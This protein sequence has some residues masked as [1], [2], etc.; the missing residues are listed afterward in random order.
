APPARTYSSPRTHRRRRLHRLLGRIDSMTVAAPVAPFLEVLRRSQLVDT[1]RLDAYLDQVREQTALPAD[2]KALATLLVK[3][4]ILTKLQAQQ[5][6]RGKHK[7]FI[8]NRKDKLL[9]LLG[10]GGMG[11]VFLCEHMLLK[12]VVAVKMLSVS[13]SSQ[14]ATAKERF[15]RE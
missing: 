2:P 3:D 15:Y 11:Q 8:V 12:R 5:L 1:K 4:A 9:E 6:L 13:K 7:G 10:I 14:D